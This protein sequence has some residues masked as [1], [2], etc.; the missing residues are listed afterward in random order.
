MYFI[1]PSFVSDLNDMFCFYFINIFLESSSSIDEFDLE[2]NEVNL[3][4][5][6]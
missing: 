6:Y 3:I 2:E 1:E 5:F 4:T